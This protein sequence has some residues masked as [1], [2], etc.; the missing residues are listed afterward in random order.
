V[1]KE[2]DGNKMKKPQKYGNI[3]HN[4]YYT[5]SCSIGDSH[6]PRRISFQILVAW[7]LHFLHATTKNSQDLEKSTSSCGP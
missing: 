7:F 1:Y 4:F 3:Q 2:S 6:T 5:E